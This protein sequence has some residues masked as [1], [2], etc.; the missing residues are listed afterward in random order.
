MSL[1]PRPHVNVDFRDGLGTPDPTPILG[2]HA[3]GAS[4]LSLTMC[5]FLFGLS[6]NLQ[7]R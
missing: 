2:R 4:R 3:L 5:L 6:E 1:T 7:E